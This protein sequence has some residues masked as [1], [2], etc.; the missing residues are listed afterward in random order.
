VQKS[1]AFLKQSPQSNY[2]DAAFNAVY[3]PV[4]WYTGA[5]SD[6]QIAVGSVIANVLTGGTDPRGGVDAMTTTLKTFSTARPPV[7]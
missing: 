4:G 1:K 5:G 6:F 3:D 2:I 7:R